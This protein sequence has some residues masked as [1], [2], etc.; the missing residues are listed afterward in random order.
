MKRIFTLIIV[1]AVSAFAQLDNTQTLTKTGTAAAQFLKIGVDAR[2]TAMGGAYAGM[3]GDLSSIHWNPSGLGYITGRD[4]EFVHNEWL[5]GMNF[6]HI[7][8]ATELGYVGILAASITSLTTPEDMVRT[9]DQPEGTGEFWDASDLAVHLSYARRLTDKFSFGASL[10]YIQQRIWHESAS[11]VAGDIGALF[12]TPFFNGMR[13]GAAISNFGGELRMEGRD[14][15]FSKDPDDF[16]QGNVQ[17]VNALYETDPFPL[18]L[19]FRVGVAGD[20][21]QNNRLRWSYA[22]DALHPNDN[23]ESLNL[24]TEVALGETFYVRAGY[25]QLFREESEEGLTVGGGIHYR[26]YG[27]SMLLKLDYAYAEFGLLDY[28]QRFSVGLTF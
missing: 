4:V 12:V 6:N 2:A 25:A 19:L 5:A 8:F 27:S 22:I 16:N 26:I 1:F 28:V 17:F 10:K 20:F 14:L 21:I 24:G 23:T 7:A 15:R 9:V 11:S 3:M 13:L 18:P